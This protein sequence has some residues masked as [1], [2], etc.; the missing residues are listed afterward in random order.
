ME[1]GRKREEREAAEI[2]SHI[3]RRE[4]R[5]ERRREGKRERQEQ[6]GYCFHRKIPVERICFD[7]K[8]LFWNSLDLET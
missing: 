1:S 6:R 5:G 3:R 2:K 8:K 4:G 7:S